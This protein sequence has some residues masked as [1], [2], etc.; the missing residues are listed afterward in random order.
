[1]SVTPQQPTLEI[2]GAFPSAEALEA[3]ISEL[4][5]AGWDRSEMSLLGRDS[6]VAGETLEVDVREKAADP[7]ADHDAV[8]S[9]PDIRQGRTLA[10]GMAGVVAAFVASGATV[11]TGGTALAAVV[12]AAVAGG[13][14]AAVVEGIASVAGKGR[15]DFLHDQLEQGGI[16]LWAKLQAPEDEAKAREILARHGATDVQVHPVATTELDRGTGGDGSPSGA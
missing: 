2:V 8:I 6:V 1:M 16:L 4:A 15:E 9:D 3:A 5:S 7:R 12:G 10:A 14:A 11:L 13:G